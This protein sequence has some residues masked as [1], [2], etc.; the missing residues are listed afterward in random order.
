MKFSK[1]LTALATAATLVAGVAIAQTQAPQPTPNTTGKHRHHLIPGQQLDSHPMVSQRI[2][3]PNAV[4]QREVPPPWCR[5]MR[6]GQELRCEELREVASKVATL[7]DGSLVPHGRLQQSPS[8]AT[9]PAAA[10][11]TC[12]QSCQLWPLQQQSRRS[13]G[14]RSFQRHVALVQTKV[15]VPRWVQR[16]MSAEAPEKSSLSGLR[17]VRFLC[18]GLIMYF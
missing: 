7:R 2:R 8:M 9:R 14:L 10:L 4:L 18:E 6:H 15:Q 12:Q 3:M 1:T 5:Q 17:S 16:S 11:P 13:R